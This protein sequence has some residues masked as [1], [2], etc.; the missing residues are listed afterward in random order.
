MA[1]PMVE[2]KEEPKMGGLSLAAEEEARAFLAELV[3]AALQA[4]ML[5]CRPAEEAAAVRAT[6]LGQASTFFLA[7]DLA[8]EMAWTAITLDRRETGE[9]VVNRVVAQVKMGKVAMSI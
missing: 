1:V 9:A 2:V 8:L 5:A 3:L 7:S 4:S 6:R